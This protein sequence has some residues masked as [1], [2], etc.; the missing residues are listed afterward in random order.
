MQ[1]WFSKEIGDGIT[2]SML[3]GEIEA[4][5]LRSAH[6]AETPADMAVFTRHESEGRLHC[7]VVAY[8]SPAAG[9][10]AA[11]FDAEP[12]EKPVRMG[13]GLLA[14]DERAWQSLFPE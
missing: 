12:C 2:A 10:V 1:T 8:F 14:G 13:L 3:M 9:A 4:E 7:A 5:F 11:I 6:G